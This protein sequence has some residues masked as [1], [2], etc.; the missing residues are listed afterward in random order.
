MLRRK[1]YAQKN[2]SRG[3]MNTR[4]VAPSGSAYLKRIVRKHDGSVKNVQDRTAGEKVDFVKTRTLQ[5]ATE[6]G[7]NPSYVGQTCNA[8]C[9]AL[10][11]TKN[12][13]VAETQGHQIEKVKSAAN[14]GDGNYWGAAPVNTDC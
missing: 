12:V 7:T 14:C 2:V 10:N 3:V 13:K 6:N 1:Y 8:G 9:G 11:V 5:C 4:A